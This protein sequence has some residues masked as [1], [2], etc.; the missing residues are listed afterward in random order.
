[1]TVVKNKAC[2][3]EGQRKNT[4]GKKQCL[5]KAVRTYFLA[6][7]DFKFSNEADAEDETKWEEAIM[8]KNVIPFYDIDED[9]ELNNTEALIKNTRFKDIETKEAVKGVNYI[10]Y[11][12][13]CSY[14]AIRSYHQDT[15]YTKVFR[16]SE[17][18]ELECVIN[19]D[20][21]VEGVPLSSFIVGVRNEPIG[22]TPASTTVSM[23]FDTYVGSILTPTPILFKT[24]G[25][26]D[27]KLEI[28][29]ESA[30]KIEF[31]AKVGCAD[32][33]DLTSIIAGNVKF[34]DEMGVPQAHTF[35]AYDP[36]SG[37]Y[38]LTGTGFLSGTLS[39]INDVFPDRTV[40]KKVNKLYESDVKIV[41]IP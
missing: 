28:R 12:D 26:Y 40:F 25:I 14:E 19:E 21:T 23:K 24:E 35:T 38:T 34:L 11:L 30:T 18:N 9:A 4:G 16:V 17:A 13:V 5:E 1:M 10:H 32:N 2:A 3:L 33:E 37:E 36:L 22:D 39:L 6:K 27:V 29:T 15:E 20:G 31:S 8:L 7:S 41:A